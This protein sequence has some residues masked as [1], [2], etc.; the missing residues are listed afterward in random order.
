VN[1]RFAHF[2]DPA[3]AKFVAN[4]LHLAQPD[5]I[6]CSND[7]TAALLMRTLIQ[8]KRQVPEMI[9]VAGFDDVQ[10]ATLLSPSLTTVRQPCRELGRSAVKALLE[11]IENPG[12][13]PRQILHSHEL[14]IRQSTKKAE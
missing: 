14:V 6:L 13:P 7:Q 10:Y 8:L 2:G 5:A 12:L 3:D 1:Y 9:A 11:R 4:V